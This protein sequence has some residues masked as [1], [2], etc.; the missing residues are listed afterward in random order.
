MD[1]S[2]VASYFTLDVITDIAFGE[3]FG[4][5]VEN[6]DINGYCKVGRASIPIFEWFGVFP[7]LYKVLR[8]PG[9]RS[10]VMPSARDTKGVGMLMG[11]VQQCLNCEN[12]CTNIYI[13]FAKP[14]VY[15]RH[16]VDAEERYDMLGSFVKKGLSHQEAE[17]ESCLQM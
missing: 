7:D 15:K 2:A 8:L 12:L 6:R 5:L 11:Y 13:R 14:L 9:I 1:F 10:L 17:A 16:S 3:P 4:F